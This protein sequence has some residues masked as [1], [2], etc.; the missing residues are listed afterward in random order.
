MAISKEEPL[1][2]PI[3]DYPIGKCQCRY[4][5]EDHPD[6]SKRTMVVIQHL[7]LFSPEQ[8][9][10]ILELQ[11]YWRVCYIDDEKSDILKQLELEYINNNRK[12]DKK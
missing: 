8:I 6:R 4:A 10:H 11:K 2:C 12:G 3:C 9:Q 5:G 7:Y 1:K